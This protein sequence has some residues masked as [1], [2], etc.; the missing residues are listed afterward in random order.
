MDLCFRLIRFFSIIAIFTFVP[1]AW[2]LDDGWYDAKS[3]T[4]PCADAMMRSTIAVDQGMP[5]S[6]TFTSEAFSFPNPVKPTKAAK[7]TKI[8]G[9]G[10]QFEVSISEPSKNNLTIKLI[11][12]SCSG[13]QI[14]YQSK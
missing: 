3:S 7:T 12:S 6:L 10:E 11:G 8:I 13:A 5:V 2:A 4:G 14:I 1:P 9:G